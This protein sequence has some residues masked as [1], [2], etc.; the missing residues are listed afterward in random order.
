MAKILNSESK[1]WHSEVLDC[2]GDTRSRRE[3]LPVAANGLPVPWYTYPA[4]EYL[5][6]IN[7]ESLRVFEYGS[8]NSSLYFARRGAKVDSVE[9]DSGWF[10]Q[11]IFKS[12]CLNSIVLRQTKEAYVKSI[13]ETKDIFDIIIIDGRWRESCQEASISYLSSAGWIILDN[14]DWYAEITLRLVNLGFFPIHFS[15]FGP[16]NEYCWTTTIFMKNICSWRSRVRPPAPVGG[17]SVHR[18]DSW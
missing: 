6:T 2:H 4:I 12:A 14:S 10:D 13:A 5:D 1:E 9:H 18:T 11:M 16:L 7:L 15:G 8:G 17:R 3:G